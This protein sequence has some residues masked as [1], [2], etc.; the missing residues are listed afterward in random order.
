VPPD[1][2]VCQRSNGYSLQRSTTKAANRGTVRA[3]SVP[4]SQRRTGS[5]V[6]PDCPVPQEDNGVNGRLLPN[7]NG[8][9]TWRRTG[10]PIVPVWCAHRQQPSPTANWWLRDINTPNH[11]NSGHPSFSEV[12]IQ[13]KS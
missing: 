2:P 9:V 1:Y 3:E 7:P 12:L 6:T 11:H 5:G 10:K 4:Q 8:W 13:F